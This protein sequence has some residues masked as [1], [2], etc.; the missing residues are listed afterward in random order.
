MNAPIYP[1]PQPT[2]Y[3]PGLP[4]SPGMI[5][6]EGTPWY[7]NPSTLIFLGVAV[8]ALAAAGKIRPRSAS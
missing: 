5:D 7:R 2:G 3:A 1:Y 4:A 6:P 8:L